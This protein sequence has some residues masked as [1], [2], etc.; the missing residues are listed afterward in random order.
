[1]NAHAMVESVSMRLVNV[2]VGDVL[3]VPPASI[4]G[5]TSECQL[6]N[7][8]HRRDVRVRRGD[9]GER[10]GYGGGIKPHQYSGYPCQ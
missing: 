3:P 5:L 4:Q 8:Q 10:D 9:R 7:I 1:V 2:F 6:N